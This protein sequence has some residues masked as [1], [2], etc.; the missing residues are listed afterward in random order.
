VNY[1]EDTFLIDEYA[2]SVSRT[3][4]QFSTVSRYVEKVLDALQIQN[5]PAHSEVMLTAYGP[6]LIETQARL[7]G[8]IDF[9]VVEECNG[10]SQVSVLA[11]SLIAP[12]LFASRAELCS[13]APSR[14]A[15]FVYMSA[16]VSGQ[17]KSAIDVDGFFKIASLMSIKLTIQAGGNLEKTKYSLGHPGYAMFLADSQEAL[18]RDYVRFRQLERQFFAGLIE[19][20]VQEES[21]ASGLHAF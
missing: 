2:D 4:P 1:H 15:R 18:C 6:R 16:D 9:A 5:G 13:A 14:F 17:I 19:E 10:Y 21:T 3:A 12:H 11:D 8:G 7:A 20:P